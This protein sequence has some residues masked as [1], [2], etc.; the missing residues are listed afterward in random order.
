MKK[1]VFSMSPRKLFSPLFSISHE[2]TANPAVPHETSVH[3]ELED[4]DASV[5]HHND[6][7]QEI[8]H[9]THAH[10]AQGIFDDHSNSS[11]ADDIVN[12]GHQEVTNKV[13]HHPDTHH[14][15]ATRAL[16]SDED[17]LVKADHT[18]NRSANHPNKDDET[19]HPS[20]DEHAESK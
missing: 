11:H 2:K 5:H 20:H 13:K 19:I 3:H 14:N 4:L 15:L 7:G 10:G 9:H 1:V 8:G 17:A 6:H 16:Q 12:N 18:S